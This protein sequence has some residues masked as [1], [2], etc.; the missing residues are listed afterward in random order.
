MRPLTWRSRASPLRWPPD[1][2][3]AGMQA[4]GTL[5]APACDP[6]CSFCP[7]SMHEHAYLPD[8]FSGC[9][10]LSMATSLDHMRPLWP[11]QVPF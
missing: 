5:A 8:L 10:A 4:A 6:L 2:T 11:A 3:P 9:H 7:V 1:W